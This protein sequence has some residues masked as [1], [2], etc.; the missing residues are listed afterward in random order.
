MLPIRDLGTRAQSNPN[1]ICSYPVFFCLLKTNISESENSEIATELMEMNEYQIQRVEDVVNHFML[2]SGD[3]DQMDEQELKV[4][5]Y[6]CLMDQC[7]DIG[8]ERINSCQKHYRHIHKIFS[9][10]DRYPSAS[11]AYFY[12]NP[13]HKE[14][15][16]MVS[17]VECDVMVNMEK[18][19]DDNDS[20]DQNDSVQ[21]ENEN[22]D[23]EATAEIL[24]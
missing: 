15:V 11:K 13:E 6:I 9:G 3:G 16:V 17:P 5:R 10:D 23:I 2:E 24:D 21:A 22:P 4:K 8:F 20:E 12:Q 14:T 18:K 7:K 19:C 1:I